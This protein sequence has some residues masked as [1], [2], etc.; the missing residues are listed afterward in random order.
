MSITA[1]RAPDLGAD[2]MP[3]LRT[4]AGPKEKFDQSSDLLEWLEGE[5]SRHGDIF[6]AKAYGMDICATRNPEH[7]QHVFRKNWTNYKRGLAV[8]RIA[9]L[10]GRGL[11][12]SEGQ[13][14]KTQRK[15]IQPTLH[16]N[17]VE[18]IVSVVT[19]AN[20]ELLTAWMDAAA[21]GRTVNATLDISRMVLKS[22][23]MAIFG[24]DYDAAAPHFAI[25][26]DETARDLEFA[27]AFLPLRA[28]VAQIAGQRKAHAGMA[29]DILGMLMAAH[30]M[31]GVPAMS[32]RQL[33]SEVI[34]LV[35]AGHE[36]TAITLNWVWY[37][38]SQHPD[39]EAELHRE[40]DLLDSRPPTVS[41][42]PR[43][44]FTRQIIEE[45][46]R[47]YPP[48]W[49]ITRRA[50]TDD[51]FGDHAVAAGTEIY[52]SPYFVQRNPALWTD[53]ERFDPWRF[54]PARSGDRP[55]LAMLA[56]GAGPRNCVGEVFA[57]IEMQLHVMMIAG[58]LR[59]HH[60]GGAPPKLHAAVNLRN[61]ADFIMT[62]QARLAP[63][64][65][66]IAGVG[67]WPRH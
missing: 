58:R 41:D 19:A 63:A 46:L 11:V 60:P 35:V 50:I 26:A 67:R 17:A 28:V 18:Q 37:L 52:I 38:L 6:D 25:L 43:A 10:M 51:R 31:H 7:V 65:H 5:F 39:A 9:M 40:L 34:T 36:T 23:L 33:V 20:A 48:L 45:A 22:V 30:D 49:L 8:K 42:F 4:L 27:H 47:L 66:D 15:L 12:V 1:R 55:E 13:L 62:P 53:P 21:R 29:P 44:P 24:D 61:A 14:W 54:S 3:S 2:T 57:R 56:F 16:R 64:Q 32:E 59:L